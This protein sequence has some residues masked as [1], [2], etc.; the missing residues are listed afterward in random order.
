MLPS[1]PHYVC[2]VERIEGAMNIPRTG[3]IVR[4]ECDAVKRIVRKVSCVIGEGED[5]RQA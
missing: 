2:H 3:Q 4:T 1:H 5:G